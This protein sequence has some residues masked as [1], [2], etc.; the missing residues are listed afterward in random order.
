M[1]GLKGK[2]LYG[3]VGFAIGLSVQYIPPSKGVQEVVT[4]PKCPC[5]EEQGQHTRTLQ[6]EAYPIPMPPP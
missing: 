3:L 1:K 2:L 4:S 6:Y 5:A